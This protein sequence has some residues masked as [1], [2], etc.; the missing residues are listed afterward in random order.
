MPVLH[1]PTK[2]LFLMCC[3]ILFIPPHHDKEKALKTFYLPHFFFSQL[4][5]INSMCIQCYNIGGRVH[6]AVEFTKSS[7]IYTT[8]R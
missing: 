5:L 4:S 1:P 2:D 7:S 8:I 6:K 3:L